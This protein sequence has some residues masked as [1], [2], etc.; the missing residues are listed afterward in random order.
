M[1]RSRQPKTVAQLLKKTELQYNQ[2]QFTKLDSLLQSFLKKN[3]IAGCR[4]GNLKNGSLLIEIPDA[5]W[6]VRLQFMRNDLLSVLREACPGLMK[7]N[8]KVNPRLSI[9]KTLPKKNKNRVKQQA[10]RMSADVADSFLALAE[11]ADPDLK[12]ALQSLAQYSKKSPP[13]KQ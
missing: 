12:K 13:E 1:N 8:I 4:L 9:S 7:V 11:D 2:P 6:M 3:N 10:K 5:N